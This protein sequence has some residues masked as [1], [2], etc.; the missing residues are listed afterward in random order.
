[1]SVSSGAGQLNDARKAAMARWE[2]MRRKW[3][4]E[5]A[6]RFESSVMRAIDEDLRKAIAAMSQIQGA[7]DKA[8]QECS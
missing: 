8:R 1:M 2:V 7:M 6:Q 5:T 3:R 4:D